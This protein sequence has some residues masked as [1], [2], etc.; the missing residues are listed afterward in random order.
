MAYAGLAMRRRGRPPH[1]DILTPREWE[2]LELLRQGL[3]NPEI[4]ERLG[5]SRAG[6]KYHVAEIL[7]KLGLSSR[8][9]AALWRPEEA[10]P[11]WVAAFAPL[12]FLWKRAGIAGA[13]LSGLALAAS[14]VLLLAVVAGLGLIAFLWLRSDGGEMQEDAFVIGANVELPLVLDGD[15]LGLSSLDGSPPVELIGPGDYTSLRYDSEGRLLY[16]QR[17]GQDPGF[18]R[19]QDG[20]PELLIPVPPLEG[21]SRA[22]WSPDGSMAAWIE[23]HEG[24][25]SL[26]VTEPGG[27]PRTLG[28]EG[29][30]WFR[31]SPD[32]KALLA[33]TGGDP[34]NTYLID[35]TGDRP[36]VEVGSFSPIDWSSAGDVVFWEGT[37]DILVRR[38]VVAKE[39]GTDRRVLGNV[40][41]QLEGPGPTATFSL[42]G[43]WL[44]WDG[45]VGEDGEWLGLV[46]AAT[47]GTTIQFPRCAPDV[48]EEESLGGHPAWSPDGTRLAWSEAAGLMVGET[49]VWEG[50]PVADGSMPFWSPDGS[51]IAY[52][53][54]QDDGSAVYAK[55]LADGGDE[56]KVVDLEDTRPLRDQAAWVPDGRNL[57]LPLQ[58][59]EQ[60][61]IYSFDTK[62]GELWQPPVPLPYPASEREL[63]ALAPD[64][65]AFAY[66]EPSGQLSLVT[67]EGDERAF[68]LSE[69][70]GIPTDWSNDGAAV[71]FVGDA[72]KVLDLETGAV[73]R[74]LEG[75]IQDAVWSPDRSRIAYV[76]DQRVGVLD[77]ATGEARIIVPDLA[78]MLLPA[79]YGEGYLAW[80]PDGKRIAFADWRFE[81]PIT[82]GRSDVYVVDA[83]GSN[84]RRLTDSPRAKRYFRW[85]PDGKHLAYVHTLDDGEHLKVIDVEA[86]AELP[87]DIRG[88][89][90]PRWVDADE[91]L[92]DVVYQGIALVKLD[93]TFRLLAQESNPCQYDLLGFAD[94]KLFFEHTCTH[95]GL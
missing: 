34:S 10:R 16:V 19:L 38:V 8:E 26:R 63:V 84:L 92:V 37:D 74:L 59:S 27:D 61:R 65:S 6:A 36:A 32:G 49:G 15:R 40:F 44:A 68:D 58:V 67:P 23:P 72:V 62:T 21:V 18:Y 31:W 29:L 64:G 57:V 4:A 35:A 7:G 78:A 83:D 85:S 42:D 30:A 75:N 69:A 87:L 43:R 13:S 70:G 12:A 94:D 55:R 22:E 89:S 47:D 71:L 25:S 60:V 91:M 5:I 95:M 24:T 17:T 45:A 48:C 56:V 9:E 14:G 28:P 39:D 76:R 81:E 46:V 41:V 73:E 82:Q 86:G 66:L 51:A 90:T 52:V 20:A 77:V 88:T 1:P 33:W 11:W 80:S 3:S 54:V 53:R 79:Q 93:G 2:V 50:R